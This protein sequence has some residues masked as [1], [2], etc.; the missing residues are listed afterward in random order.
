MSIT[1]TNEDLYKNTYAL[2]VLKE[3]IYAVSLRDILKTQRLTADFC[4]KYI[5]NPNFQIT[6]EDES[7]T[8]ELVKEWQ[9]HI[10]KEEL[11]V[12][13]VDAAKKRRNKQRVDSFEDFDSFAK[14]HL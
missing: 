14:R 6:A 13:Q 9:P 3:N 5:L 11:V 2:S 12:A 1:I 8:V 7:I 10:S 4:V